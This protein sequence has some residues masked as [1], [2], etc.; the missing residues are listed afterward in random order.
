MNPTAAWL[1]VTGSVLG[2]AQTAVKPPATAARVPLATVSS[3]SFPGS[4]KCTCTSTRPGATIMPATLRTSAP[5]GAPIPAP[6]AAILPSWTSGS[7]AGQQVEH[8]HAH[9]HAVGHLVED[10]AVGT[11]G[12]ARVDFDAAVHRTG[13]HDGDRPRRALEPL[14]GDAEHAVIL[15]Q[16]GDE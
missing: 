12:H 2:M 13:V 6:T 4:R 8:G 14:A 1:S 10:H 16:R 15:A 3:S 11:V 9:R 7:A 5:S